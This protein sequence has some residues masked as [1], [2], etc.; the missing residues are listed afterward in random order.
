MIG[1]IIT[2]EEDYN[3][4]QRKAREVKFTQV[5]SDAKALDVLVGTVQPDL[6]YLSNIG[7]YPDKTIKI[8]QKY[9]AN[10]TPE[11]MCTVSSNT[12]EFND[13]YIHH[14]DSYQTFY[15][16]DEKVEP[17]S[18]ITYELY[19]EE[20]DEATNVPIEIV[21]TDRNADYGLVLKLY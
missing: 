8:G 7:Y 9:V 4:L 20:S 2:E 19:D 17:G 18:K 16:Q 3:E 5:I 21:G 15:Y 6:I 10:G 12:E 11:V 14:P 13:V 1:D